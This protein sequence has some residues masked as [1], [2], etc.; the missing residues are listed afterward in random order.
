MHLNPHRM[1]M[2]MAQARRLRGAAL[3]AA[4]RAGC[5]SVHCSAPLSGPVA[6]REALAVV[7]QRLMRRPDGDAQ[8]AARTDAKALLADALRPRLGHSNDVILC[9]DREVRRRI[10]V[11][12]IQMVAV[13]Q[14]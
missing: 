4:Q 9:L 6:V 2:A 13:V 14:T 8:A 7:Q 5:R 10:S 11:V 3:L 1:A 12:F